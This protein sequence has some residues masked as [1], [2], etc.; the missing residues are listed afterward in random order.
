MH[1]WYESFNRG[2]ELYGYL[3]PLIRR[4]PWLVE[5]QCRP[6][7]SLS[8]FALVWRVGN[9]EGVDILRGN[10]FQ[11]AEWVGGRHAKG[12][13]GGRGTTMILYCAFLYSTMLG[14]SWEC[15]L[16]E[17]GGERGNSGYIFEI[18]TFLSL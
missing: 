15:M 13:G 6:D 18:P 5:L 7:P 17:E 14:V 4:V 10:G 9:G 1:S 16:G 11:Q 12:N 2:T 8:A 3:R